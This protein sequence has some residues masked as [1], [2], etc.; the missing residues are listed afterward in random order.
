MQFS[1]STE[2]IAKTNFF[3]H[4]TADKLMKNTSQKSALSC[5]AYPKSL[6]KNATGNSTPQK[7]CERIH[8]LENQIIIIE[9]I[10]STVNHKMRLMHV[11]AL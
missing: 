11:L 2:S 9:S 7:K 3:S 1:Y 6:D 10:K 8:V 5:H 4:I